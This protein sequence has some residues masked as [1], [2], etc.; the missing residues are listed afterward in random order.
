MRTLIEEGEVL[1]ALG[2]AERLAKESPI[3]NRKEEL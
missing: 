1:A 3:D 2:L